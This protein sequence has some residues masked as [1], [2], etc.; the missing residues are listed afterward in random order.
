MAKRYHVSLSG[1]ERADLEALV[2]RRSERAEPVKRALMLLA[3]DEADGAPALPDGVE[4]DGEV[5]SDLAVRVAGAVGAGEH[6]SGP[7]RDRLCGRRPSCP[8]LEG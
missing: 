5:A 2:A 4:T 7:K 1:N 6:D 3:A 8:L